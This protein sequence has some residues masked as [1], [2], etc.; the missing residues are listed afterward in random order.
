MFLNNVKYNIPIAVIIGNKTYSSGEFCASIFY[1]NDRK[2]KIFGQ[3]TGGGLSV[4]NTFDI[5]DDIKLNISIQLVTTVDGHFHTKQYLEPNNKTTNQ[6]R[7][8]KNGLILINL[9]TV[10]KINYLNV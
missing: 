6:L 8:R 10:Y 3:R 7:L 2:I 4:N 5:T 9:K 1:R